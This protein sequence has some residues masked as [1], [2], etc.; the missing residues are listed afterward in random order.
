MMSFRPASRRPFFIRNTS[1]VRLPTLQGSP[2]RPLP[3][4]SRS[5]RWSGGGAGGGARASGGRRSPRT[6][7]PR[8]L[9]GPADEIGTLNMMT[10]ASRLEVLKQVANGKVYDLG[11]D[12]FVGMPNCWS[13]RG[14]DLP[15]LDDAHAR[16][17]HRPRNCCLTPAPISMYTHSGTHPDTPSI[18]SGCRGRSGIESTPTTHSACGVDQIRGRQIPSHCGPGRAHR[19][20][21]VQERGALAR[22]VFHHG[23]RP[24]GGAEETRHDAS[25]GRCGPDTDRAHDPVAR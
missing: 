20:G 9:R 10:D 24:A 11:V 15:D 5:S 1:P 13:L 18:T 2:G 6:L 14:S 12:L 22:V 7:R 19:C 8:A 16:P 21:Q 17:R 4:W 25:P 3:R 23:G